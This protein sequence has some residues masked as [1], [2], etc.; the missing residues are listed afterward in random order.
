M[1]AG[2]QQHNRLRQLTMPHSWVFK[3]NTFYVEVV[4]HTHKLT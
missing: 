4:E 3:K 2:I 1:L